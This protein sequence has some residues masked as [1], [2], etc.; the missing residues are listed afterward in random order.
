MGILLIIT[1]SIWMMQTRAQAISE[2][3]LHFCE[4]SVAVEPKGSEELEL[5]YIGGGKYY[6]ETIKWKVISGKKNIK[7]IKIKGT[8]TQMRVVGL[9]EGV[10]KVQITH[11]KQKLTCTVTVTKN[12]KLLRI[13]KADQDTVKKVHDRLMKGKETY[14]FTNKKSKKKAEVLIKKLSKK[15]GKYNSCGVGIDIDDCYERYHNN[16]SG[17]P[18]KERKNYYYKLS[19]DDVEGY[20]SSINAVKK[21]FAKAKQINNEAVKER[22]A[23]VEKQREEISKQENTTSDSTYKDVFEKITGIPY[24]KKN[25]GTVENSDRYN[26]LD[27]QAAKSKTIDVHNNEMYYRLPRE[28]YFISWVHNGKTYYYCD[29]YVCLEQGDAQ[30]NDYDNYLLKFTSA[31]MEGQLDYRLKLSEVTVHYQ[32][33]E[34]PASEKCNLNGDEPIWKSDWDWYSDDMLPMDKDHSQN[35]DDRQRMLAHDKDPFIYIESNTEGE[36]QLPQDWYYFSYKNEKGETI[37]STVRDVSLSQENADRDDYGNYTFDF[38]GETLKFSEITFYYTPLTVDLSAV[39]KKIDADKK[40]DI[41]KKLKE[42]LYGVGINEYIRKT[43][44]ES[45]IEKA[46]KFYNFSQAMQAYCLI[47]T[48]CRYNGNKT[49]REIKEICAYMRI[50]LADNFDIHHEVKVTNSKGKTAYISFDPDASGGST[51]GYYE[52]NGKRKR[53]TNFVN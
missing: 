52:K 22:K 33:D 28:W 37:Y 49:F 18:Q 6:R 15:L 50:P 51:T 17:I 24:E 4:K 23:F 53:I 29:R 39:Q 38:Q 30:R 13:T 8:D 25:Y 32:C 26:Y 12:N 3:N 7:L 48:Y 40:A 1:V 45:S 36:Y 5:T 43:N 20:K 16:L 34:Y 19:H 21:W 27:G 41:E 47:D 9:K 46:K 2:L 42:R 11:R 44:Y 10:S 35:E 31:N 14:L